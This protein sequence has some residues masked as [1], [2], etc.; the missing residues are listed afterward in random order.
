[1]RVCCLLR[2]GRQTL[3]ARRYVSVTAP[4]TL[5]NLNVACKSPI[6]RSGVLTLY[7]FGVRVRMRSGHLEIEDGIG[8]ERRRIRLARVG[9]GLR[10]L[11]MIGSDGF[12]TFEALRWLA[13]QDASFVMLDR[14]G[15]VL[16]TTGPVRPSDAR[17]RRAQAMAMQT[18]AALHITRELIGQKL[19]GQERVARKNLLDSKTADLIA[20][21]RGAVE[22]AVTIDAIRHLESQG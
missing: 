13:N 1:M 15:S 20:K 8:S 19:A 7:G 22:S 11:V 4:Y 16:V 18:G 12:V 10:R 17:L 21:L 3:T 2:A 5:S 14:D 6:S 9:H